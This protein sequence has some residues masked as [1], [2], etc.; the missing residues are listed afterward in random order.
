MSGPLLLY[1]GSRLSLTQYQQLRDRVDAA[2]PKDITWSQTITPPTSA[3]DLASEA[4]FVICN[5]G[6]RATVARPIYEKVMAALQRGDQT[7]TVFKHPHKATSI[8]SIWA[9]RHALLASFQAAIDQLAWC[10]ALPHIG[11][12]TKYHLAKNLGVDCAKPDRWLVRVAQCGGETVDALCQRLARAHGDRV[13]TVDY[14]IWRSCEQGWLT[15]S[16]VAVSALTVETVTGYDAFVRLIADDPAISAV[17]CIRQLRE[18]GVDTDEAARWHGQWQ[19]LL[20]ALVVRIGTLS[21]ILTAVPDDRAGVHR[22]VRGSGSQAA[23]CDFSA[24]AA[25]LALAATAFNHLFR[26]PSSFTE[27]TP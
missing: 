2:F 10:D 21:P 6:M 23:T 4:I 25:V 26:L 27:R 20:Q 19:A 24:D 1:Q 13:A 5:S 8:D 14:V 7:R 18:Q 11:G 16:Q 22:L 9:T 3:D 15:P 17:D 12:I